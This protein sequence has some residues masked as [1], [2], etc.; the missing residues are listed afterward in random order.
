MALRRLLDESFVP[1]ERLDREKVES[2]V[3]WMRTVECF[4]LP[5]SSLD[6]AVGLL[7]SLTQGRIAE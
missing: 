5:L 6:T 1:L 3:Q 2:L 4:E 7:R